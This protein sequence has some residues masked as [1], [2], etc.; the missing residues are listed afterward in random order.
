MAEFIGF[1]T[2]V[3][4]FFTRIGRRSYYLLLASQFFASPSSN[5]A[6]CPM[7]IPSYSFFLFDTSHFYLLHRGGLTPRI[8]M[9]RNRL[10]NPNPHC[11]HTIIILTIYS[12]VM[13]ISR[14]FKSW[15]FQNLFACAQFSVR[16]ECV[17]IRVNTRSCSLVGDI[18]DA[19][20]RNHFF[21][22]KRHAQII[23]DE[24]YIGKIEVHRTLYFSLTYVTFFCA[25]G[26]RWD[27]LRPFLG[28]VSN[29]GIVGLSF[30]PG[31]GLHPLSP[32][33]F[34]TVGL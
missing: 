23:E 27:L 25:S 1:F 31:G 12:H 29:H 8:G 7:L 33:A 2:F 34:S 9:I 24:T 10:N 19:T 14:T 28:S 6:C 17:C 13:D 22:T 32:Y 3:C 26:R 4:L 30:T 5:A 20:L 18:A 15:G 16:Y 11:L 21:Y